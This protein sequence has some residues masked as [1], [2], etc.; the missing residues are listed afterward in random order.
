MQWYTF[1]E[2]DIASILM[3]KL[4][5]IIN[6]YNNKNQKKTQNRPMKL[7]GMGQ[8]SSI[9]CNAHAIYYTHTS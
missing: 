5:N 1:Y 7:I 3:L 4:L 6:V 2:N 8:M 9:W